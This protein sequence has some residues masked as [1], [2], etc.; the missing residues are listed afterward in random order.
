MPQ[1]LPGKETPIETGIIARL[2]RGV[3]A[4]VKEVAPSLQWLGPGEPLWVRCP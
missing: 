1:Q 2:G 3:R 4:F